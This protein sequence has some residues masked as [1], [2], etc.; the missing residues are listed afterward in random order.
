MCVNICMSMWVTHHYPVPWD[1]S[2]DAHL[3]APLL[4]TEPSE[5]SAVY[6]LLLL[7]FALSLFISLTH[8]H[9]HLFSL[10]LSLTFSLHLPPAPCST[11]PF[12]THSTLSCV[13][14]ILSLT[15]LPPSLFITAPLCI[16]LC[17]SSLIQ[18]QTVSNSIRFC[19]TLSVSGLSL[20]V[21]R[22]V[23][24]EIDRHQERRWQRKEWNERCIWKVKEDSAF[25]TFKLYISNEAEDDMTTDIML[26]P[27][28]LCTDVLLHILIIALPSSPSLSS[29]HTHSIRL[30]KDEQLLCRQPTPSPFGQL[31]LCPAA[32]C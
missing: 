1:S 5:P 26:I 9:A 8:S 7:L 19:Q 6:T 28:L 32:D 30:Q 25:R 20:L 10:R 15:N 21:H 27:N 18:T 12:L 24:R 4:Q 14:S 29:K 2:S 13:L 31:Q 17:R 11:S 23:A 3:S 16:Y 22:C